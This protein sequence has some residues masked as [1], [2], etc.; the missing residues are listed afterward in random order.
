MQNQS[1]NYVGHVGKKRRNR[2]NVGEGVEKTLGFEEY[3]TTVIKSLPF[4]ESMSLEI[5]MKSILIRSAAHVI[6]NLHAEILTH[7]CIQR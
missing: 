3:Q 7:T 6:P 5:D 2:R 1:L 4:L